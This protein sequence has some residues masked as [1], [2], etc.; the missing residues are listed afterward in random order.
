MRPTLPEA[1]RVPRIITPLN[2]VRK[3][4]THN[5][6][7]LK[8]RARRLKQPM[9]PNRRSRRTTVGPPA[10]DASDHRWKHLRAVGPCWRRPPIGPVMFVLTARLCEGAQ[11]AGFAGLEQSFCGASWHYVSKFQR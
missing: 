10:G 1:R 6:L 2:L 11:F 3:A 5:N 7:P 9:P 4:P 8:A